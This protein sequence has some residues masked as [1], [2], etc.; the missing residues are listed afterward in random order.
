VSRIYAMLVPD[1][2]LGR[3]INERLRKAAEVSASLRVRG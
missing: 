2:G 1:H 3:A